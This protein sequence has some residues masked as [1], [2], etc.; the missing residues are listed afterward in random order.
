MS[1]AV[2]FCF[3][4]L[5]RACSCLVD[6]F[7]KP[8]MTFTSWSLDVPT[9]RDSYFVLLKRTVI[10]K[11]R[12]G[13]WGG[14]SCFPRARLLNCLSCIQWNTEWIDESHISLRLQMPSAII[15]KDQPADHI[16]PYAPPLSYCDRFSQTSCSSRQ[17]RHDLGETQESSGQAGILSNLSDVNNITSNVSEISLW[18]KGPCTNV[19]HINLRKLTKKEGLGERKEELKRF[20]SR[21]TCSPVCRGS[22]NRNILSKPA[23]ETERP[24]EKLFCMGDPPFQSELALGL[25]AER[26]TSFRSLGAN[27]KVPQ[28][29]SH[30]AN[31]WRHLL[32]HKLEFCCM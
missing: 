30:I 29:L 26:S 20:T 14:S 19:S 2:V 16:W 7:S 13:E 9:F 11:M 25:N 17:T 1:D 6:S 3:C 22:Y 23:R 31:Y 21:D 10:F 27:K 15:K 24:N 28:E 18:K 12:W 5:H 32:K 4:W 8:H